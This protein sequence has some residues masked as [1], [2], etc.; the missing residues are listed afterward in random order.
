MATGSSNRAEIPMK[1]KKMKVRLALRHEGHF[2]NAYLAR[3]DTMDGAKLI[4]SIAFG[5]AMKDPEIKTAFRELMQ[6]V[7]EGAIIDV[8]G[9]VPDEW[10]IGPAA[11]A[12]RSGHS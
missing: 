5:A 12:E 10:V 1:T 6:K 7:M 4:G 3:V 8:T 11:E 9:V 2:W